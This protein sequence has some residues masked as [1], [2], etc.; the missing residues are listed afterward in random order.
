MDGLTATRVVRDELGLT[1]LP[2]I[3]FTAGVLDEERQRALE[4][5]VNDFLAKPVD[6]EALVAIIRRWV[7][8][9]AGTGLRRHGDPPMAPDVGDG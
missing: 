2:V 5:G 4:A 1:A 9:L 3:A 7:T 8:P 6:L